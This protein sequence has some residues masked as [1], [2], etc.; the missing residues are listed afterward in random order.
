M[1][2]IQYD[3]IQLSNNANK[4]NATSLS[5]SFVACDGA[6]SNEDI[7]N[8]HRIHH[9]LLI[10]NLLS[11][12]RN[13]FG[14]LVDVWCSRNDPKHTHTLTHV[15]NLF[16]TSRINSLC[17]SI[18][19]WICT[20]THTHKLTYLRYWYTHCASMW[21]CDWEDMYR[22]KSVACARCI[23]WCLCCQVRWFMWKGGFIC[24]WLWF[25]ALYFWLLGIQPEGFNRDLGRM[26]SYTW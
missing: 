16:T 25:T 11:N 20:H 9:I 15:D 17:P 13:A 21:V 8:S 19:H 2:S 3:R 24:W 7:N 14:G 4:T 22:E 26:D 1:Y 6:S 23:I 12:R 18:K 10:A 5:F